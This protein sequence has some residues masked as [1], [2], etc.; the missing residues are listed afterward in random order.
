VKASL[1][2]ITAKALR[3]KAVAG[4]TELLTDE[5]SEAWVF[6]VSPSLVPLLA[7]AGEKTAA[8]AK[9]WSATAEMKADGWTAAATKKLVDDL[10]TLAGAATKSQTDVLRMSL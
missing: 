7:K 6:L 4:D 8:I 5:E 1:E 3:A 2:K 10:I 9:T